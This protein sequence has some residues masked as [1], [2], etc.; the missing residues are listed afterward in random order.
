MKS[1]EDELFS[2]FRSGHFLIVHIY[3]DIHDHP[4]ELDYLK[5]L[6]LSWRNSASIRDKALSK[7]KIINALLFIRMSLVLVLSFYLFISPPT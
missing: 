4:N 1:T 7:F 6:V 5:Y 3:S 2:I